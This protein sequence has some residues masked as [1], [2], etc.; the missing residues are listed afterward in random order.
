MKLLLEY[1]VANDRDNYLVQ[2]H[3]CLKIG[4]KPCKCICMVWPWLVVEESYQWKY[5]EVAKECYRKKDAVEYVDTCPTLQWVI[6]DM[7]CS[8][9]YVSLQG[10][11][12]EYPDEYLDNRHHKYPKYNAAE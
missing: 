4:V 3:L 7:V 12:W 1:K 10:S 6:D 2:H 11:A 8:S 9:R 5:Q